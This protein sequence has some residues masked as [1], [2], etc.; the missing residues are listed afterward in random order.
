MDAE[1]EGSAKLAEHHQN[2]D[3]QNLAFRY[4][5]IVLI[6]SRYVSIGTRTHTT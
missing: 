6:A 1:A 3:I 4:Y 2:P 5:N